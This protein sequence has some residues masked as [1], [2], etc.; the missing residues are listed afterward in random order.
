MTLPVLQGEIDG[1]SVT[2]PKMNGGQSGSLLAT[3]GDLQAS[4]R[5]RQVPALPYSED[6]ESTGPGLIPGGWTNTQLR[7]V[8]T[9]LDNGNTVL[10]KTATIAVPFYRQWYA[11][12]GTPDQSGHTISA[13]VM[14]EQVRENMPN[15]GL[16]AHRYI[17]QIVGD[18]LF[19]V[20][21]NGVDAAHLRVPNAIALHPRA[22]TS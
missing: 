22:W 16:T 12:I 1:A 3:A 6:F 17:L 19:L 15:M 9:K 21:S 14:G 8:T 11:F 4:I 7:Y 18:T 5:A 10:M 2:A 20:T 13:D